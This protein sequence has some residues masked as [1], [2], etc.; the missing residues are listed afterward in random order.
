MGQP[1]RPLG[2]MVGLLQLIVLSGDPS[3]SSF[4]QKEVVL[5][6]E[7]AV[8]EEASRIAESSVLASLREPY[9][10]S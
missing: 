10:T 8:L 6:R 9:V 4:L 2:S 3:D 1:P 5:P 7:S